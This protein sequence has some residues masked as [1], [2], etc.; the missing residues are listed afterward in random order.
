MLSSL[1]SWLSWMCFPHWRREEL[2]YCGELRSVFGRMGVLLLAKEYSE[3]G[4]CCWRNDRGVMGSDILFNRGSGE[5]F[6]LAEGVEG[7]IYV[8]GGVVK[9][10]KLVVGS[11]S[12]LI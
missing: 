9:A 4:F 6:C 2:S 10:Y 11:F 5:L 12:S 7:V 8:S 1:R 3:G